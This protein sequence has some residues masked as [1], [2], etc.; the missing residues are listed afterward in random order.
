MSTI[1]RNCIF[2]FKCDKKWEELRA[3]TTSNIHFCDACQRAVYFCRTDSELHEAIVLN[4]CVA[5]EFEN[6]SGEREQLLGDFQGFND[7]RNNAF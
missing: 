7:D 6:S 1:I 5:V 2:A 4:R 3:T